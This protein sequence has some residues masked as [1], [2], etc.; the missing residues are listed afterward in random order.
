MRQV[1]RTLPVLMIIILLCAAF[2]PA[3]DAAEPDAI[4][5]MW[6][7]AEKD[8]KIDV[9]PCGEAYC[10]RI[11]WLKT[12]DY[13]ADSE[14]GVPGTPKLDHNNPDKALRKMPVIGLQIVRDFRFDGENRWSGGLVYDPKNGKTYKGKMTLV[15]PDRLD[16]RGYIGISLIGRT[17]IWT[18]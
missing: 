1:P 16:L 4:V 17:T 2:A 10:G 5:G 3:A 18:R 9:F 11:V 15:A 6:N 13:P 8:A 12:P 7:N 14:D